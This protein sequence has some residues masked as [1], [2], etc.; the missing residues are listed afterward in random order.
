MFGSEVHIC[1]HCEDRCTGKYCKNCQTK[2]QRA[3]MDK[4]NRELFASKG[5]IFN[6]RCTDEKN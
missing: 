1:A 5:L 6:H 2:A 3:E 4:N